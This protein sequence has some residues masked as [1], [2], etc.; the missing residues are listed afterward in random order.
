MYYQYW[1]I[2]VPFVK[3]ELLLP[4][5]EPQLWCFSTIGHTMQLDP[6]LDQGLTLVN[7]VSGEIGL[8][9]E[10]QGVLVLDV[11]LV[12]VWRIADA[13]DSVYER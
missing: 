10:D 5:V 7:M 1:G 2:S 6:V 13:I 4:V 9:F 11:V 12:E 3:A 8:M